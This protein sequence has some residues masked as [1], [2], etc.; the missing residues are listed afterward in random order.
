MSLQVLIVQPD[1]NSTHFM[2]D[3]FIEWGDQVLHTTDIEAARTFLK[4]NE[5]E[6]V[7]WDLH[8][9]VDG[10]DKLLIE[11]HEQ[12]PQTKILFTANY[13]DPQKESIARQKYG[14]QVILRQPVTRLA[15]EQAL[16]ALEGDN[17][18][19]D[20]GFDANLPRVRVPVRAKITLP[21]AILALILAVAAAY[22]ISQVVVDTIEERFTNQLIEAAQL[23]NDWMVSEEDRLLETLR[24]MT[25]TQGMQQA[26]AA[27][28]AEQLRQL[29]LPL[30][31]NYQEEAVEILDAQG[32]SMLSMR[33][34]TGSTL[35]DYEIVRGEDVFQKWEFVRSVLAQSIDQGRDKYAG[36]ARASW[37]DY[38]YVAGPITDSD[39]NLVGVVMVGKSLP[40]LVKQLRQDTLAHITIYDFTGQRI[41][42]TLPVF[43]EELQALDAGMVYDTLEGQD[44]TSVIHPL[45]IAS[46]DYSEILGP[47]EV[48][49]F[50][51]PDAKRNNYDLGLLG[52]SMAETFLARPSQVTRIR[53]FVAAVIAFGLVITLGVFL[54]GRIT[55]PL[56]QVVSATSQVAGGNLDVEVDATGNDEV[57]VLGHSFNRM[58]AGL[59]E[60]SI[61]RDLFGRTVSPEVREQLRQSFA[62]G[63]LNLE[64]QEAVASVLMSDIRGFTSISEAETPATILS[65]LNEFFAELVPII[66]SHGG[67]ISKFE[68]DAVLAFFGILPRPISAQESAFRACQTALAMLDAIER[69]NLRREAR[70][71]PVFA[72]GI[73]VN[74]GPVTAGGLGSADRLHYTIIGDTVN[75]TARLESLTRQ[76]G[77]GNA[78]VI[79][80]HTLF[81]LRKRRHEFEM[82]SMGAHTVKGKEEQLLVY[83]LRRSQ[84]TE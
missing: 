49:E 14:A 75:T 81:A 33:H 36:L 12:F 10:S 43:Q 20:S 45:T 46:I 73:G 5:P 25:Y 21:Y 68:G 44:E 51:S 24:L 52:V 80:Q 16:R 26:I 72:V 22:L 18:I 7:V 77:Q 65:W 3:L 30:A 67:V 79:S 32:V 74:T 48:R 27:Q 15:M 83:R 8:L 60:G 70:G 66:T 57:A 1:S 50:L 78:A 82:E 37:G 64:G 2:A 6:L 59:R 63:E 11:I 55:S 31:I 69:I 61:Y 40:S 47:W 54:A 19:V 38:L 29:V 58:I 9:A 17:P 56:L 84:A 4:Q 34:R 23:T 53:I 35:E 39:N 13:P 28:D 41:I 62:S 76:F 42:S 71:D